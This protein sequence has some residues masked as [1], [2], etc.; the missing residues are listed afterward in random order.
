[1]ADATGGQPAT[2]V[3][4][5]R[6]DD[7]R[8]RER[9]L[10]QRQPF[11]DIVAEALEQESVAGHDGSRAFAPQSQKVPIEDVMHVTHA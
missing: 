5:L 1:V 2:D 8:A 9:S 4:T 10:D 3:A 7:E 11:I 6:T